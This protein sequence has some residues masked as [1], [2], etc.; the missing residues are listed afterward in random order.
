MLSGVREDGRNT[1]KALCP[2]H[3]GDGGNHT[4]SLQVTEA[5]DGKVLVYCHVCKDRDIGPKICSKFGISIRSLFP[6]YGRR[7]TNGHTHS[8][9][10]YGHASNK[11]PA[12]R[13][14]AA[15]QYR[16]ERGELLFEVCRLDPKDFR[17]R[18]PGADGGWT[19]STKGVRRV[20]YHLPELLAQPSPKV[21]ITEGEKD[22]DR[23]RTIGLVATCNAGGAGKWKFEP[24][25]LEP[26]RG[27]E[28]V[29][30]PDNDEPGRNHAQDVAR[31]LAG[32]AN[33]VRIVALPGLPAKGD[34]SDW[35]DAG[36]TP[37]QLHQLSDAAEIFTPGQA[38]E[39]PT[40]DETPRDFAPIEADDDP[41]RLARL[42]V[43]TKYRS[44]DG[45]LTLL[46]YRGEFLRWDNNAWR[47][48]VQSELRSDLS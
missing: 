42:F 4:P 3:E 24:S 44:G 47:P 29:I 2:I 18:K 41:H 16:D 5:D 10:K 39:S 30:L 25:D 21:Y 7:E 19:W 48:I 1:W 20:L 43:A 35:L 9:K 26:L 15:Y 13:I 23:L 33:E 11:P 32:I 17:Q 28:I 38:D 31:S 46:H 37:E 14:V 27:R 12:G 36:G 6:D 45:E 40:H 22:V 8:A 34:V